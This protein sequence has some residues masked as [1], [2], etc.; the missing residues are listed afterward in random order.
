M[1]NHRPARGFE[2]DGPYA[3]AVVELAEGPRMMTNI[4]GIPNTPED[5]ILDMA[6]QVTLRAARRHQ[7]ARLRGQ[8]EKS[9]EPG[10]RC[11][12]RRGSRDRRDR[13]A[14]GPLDPS[15]AHRGRGERRRRRGPDACATS[16]ASPPSTRRARSR[17]R[18]RSASRRRWMDGTAV[19]RHLVPAACPARRGRDPGRLC[20]D[21]PDHPRRIRPLEGGSDPV[22][23]RSV[24]HPR[25]VRGALRYGRARPRRSPSRCSGT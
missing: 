21:G 24:V 9:N 2:D 15:A 3:I 1:I 8:Q 5:L 13:Q 10:T 23:S 16:T 4:V 22:P 7:P 11:D 19:G 17:S 25:P 18:T 20:D 12:H 6:L 14:A